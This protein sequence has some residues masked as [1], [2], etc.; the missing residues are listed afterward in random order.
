MH[1]IQAANQRTTLDRYRSTF[2]LLPAV[3]PAVTLPT[4]LL[5]KLPRSTAGCTSP[6]LYCSYRNMLS[7]PGT[8]L[9]GLTA[10]L[11]EQSCLQYIF[12][13]CLLASFHVAEYNSSSRVKAASLHRCVAAASSNSPAPSSQPARYTKRNRVTTQ[14]PQNPQPVLSGN[15]RLHQP[16]MSILENSA[17]SRSDTERHADL[18]GVRVRPEGRHTAQELWCQTSPLFADTQVRVLRNSTASLP[19]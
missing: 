5:L 17:V 8:Y 2:P 1:P 15:S 7:F 4:Q 6:L 3:H 16:H 14:N 13:S 19:L 9:V 12:P 11:A 18:S 10:L